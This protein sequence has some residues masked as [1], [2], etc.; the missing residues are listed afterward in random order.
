MDKAA[1]HAA[2]ECGN[3]KERNSPEAIAAREALFLSRSKNST[4]GRGR[5]APARGNYGQCES[6]PYRSVSDEIEFQA[7]EREARLAQDRQERENRRDPFRCH[8]HGLDLT[9]NPFTGERDN[10]RARFQDNISALYNNIDNRTPFKDDLND[11]TNEMEVDD[12][13]PF[14][15]YSHQQDPYNEIKGLEYR[16]ELPPPPL[17]EA[18]IPSSHNVTSIA[19]EENESQH[20]SD[21]GT[22]VEDG[23]EIEYPSI[24]SRFETDQDYSAWCSLL[25]EDSQYGDGLSIS[26]LRNEVRRPD[27]NK[28]PTAEEQETLDHVNLFTNILPLAPLAPPAQ[29]NQAI[30]SLLD[31]TIGTA[32]ANMAVGQ[33]E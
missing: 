27:D 15:L 1:S 25:R 20:A 14:S 23:E 28:P 6:R 29:V 7:K 22:Q 31:G 3:F 8:S 13:E 9:V 32:H 4:R 17:D 19:E 2:T 24:R 30:D 21:S 10:N 12:E 16:S 26:D 5:D 33:Q 11:D 18:V